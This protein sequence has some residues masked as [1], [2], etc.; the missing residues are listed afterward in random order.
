MLFAQRGGPAQWVAPDSPAA[1]AAEWDDEQVA[2]G[3]RRVANGTPLSDARGSA[4]PAQEPLPQPPS[5]VESAAAARVA[6]EASGAAA[7][8]AAQPG[9]GVP[10]G[11]FVR[12]ETMLGREEKIEQRKA[13]RF[14]ERRMKLVGYLAEEIANTFGGEK[15][16]YIADMHGVLKEVPDAS[17]ELYLSDKLEEPTTEVI[18][19]RVPSVL[20]PRMEA[21]EHG[22]WHS[23]PVRD[24]M[25]MVGEL[26]PARQ[27]WCKWWDKDTGCGE[28][29]DLDDQGPVAVV[30][31]ALTTGA[32]VS[33]RLKYLRNGEFVEY[34]RVFVEHS[35]AARA[36]LVRGL[37][38]W[39][40]MCEVVEADDGSRS[41]PP[42][43]P[44]R[45]TA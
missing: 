31:A 33:P 14:V 32:N 40:L 44:G 25:E 2:A 28:I 21:P 10:G 24:K 1:A 41:L 27:G 36:V 19:S 42:S 35:V 16:R 34:R 9:G 12:T 15:E 8:E 29:V 7:E 45:A 39:P 3:S 13:Q 11:D 37:K 20:G 43:R 17:R 4:Q 22:A 38:G 26:G 5:G 23:E 30:S 18:A 6:W